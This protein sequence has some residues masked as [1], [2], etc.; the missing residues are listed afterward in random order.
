MIKQEHRG[1]KYRLK[2]A[3]KDIADMCKLKNTWSIYFDD[4]YVGDVKESPRGGFYYK[5]LF[6]D[7]GSCVCNDS[8]H[9][10]VRCMIDSMID[11]LK[12][13]KYAMEIKKV[14]KSEKLFVKQLKN[15][16]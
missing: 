15:K 5:S 14:R 12:F 1:Y 2:K 16:S 11:S 10:S 8:L 4:L 7:R 9:S 3:P 6:T 13:F